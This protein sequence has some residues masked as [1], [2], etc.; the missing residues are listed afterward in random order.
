MAGRAA[1][2]TMAFVQDLDDTYTNVF[3]YVS[4][5]D[6]P[7]GPGLGYEEALKAEY[8]L[9]HAIHNCIGEIYFEFYRTTETDKVYLDERKANLVELLKQRGWR[10]LGPTLLDDHVGMLLGLNTSQ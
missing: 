7:F 6:S 4:V 3:Q 8:P 10:S 5:F 2:G 9:C 1:N